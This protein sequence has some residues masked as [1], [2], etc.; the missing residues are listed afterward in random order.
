M[1][2]IPPATFDAFRD[3]GVLAA[4]LERDFEGAK[5]QL[6]TLE[7]NGISLKEV[8]DELLVDGVKQFA[9]AFDK[10]MAAVDK[11]LQSAKKS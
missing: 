3:H 5:K 9:D 11:S 8:T 4:T 1:N 10:L 6:A 2:T 7:K